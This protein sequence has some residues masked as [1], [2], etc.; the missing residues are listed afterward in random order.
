MENSWLQDRLGLPGWVW[1]VAKAHSADGQQTWAWTCS[2]PGSKGASSIWTGLDYHPALQECL[3]QSPR[4]AVTGV[5]ALWGGEEGFGLVHPVAEVVLGGPLQHPASTYKDDME[6]I[7][8]GSSA[9]CITGEQVSE[10][11][12]WD[13]IWQLEFFLYSEIVRSC[14]LSHVCSVSGPD[15]KKL[16]VTWS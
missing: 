6:R 4:W 5:L 12:G 8:P 3:Q 11:T 15:W 2:D 16:C 14:C 13:G 7:E 10:G 9:W 1:S